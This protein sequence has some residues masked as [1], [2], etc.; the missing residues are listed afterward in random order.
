[1]RSWLWGWFLGTGIL[2]VACGGKVIVDGLPED[3]T[4]G[5]GGGGAT[6]TGSTTS[7]TSTTGTASTGGA[8]MACV[9]KVCNTLCTVCNN[10]ECIQGKCDSFGICV[11]NQPKCP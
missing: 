2:L 3:G 9:G 8:L 10:T 4:G 1:M 7:G 5:A 11:P 6:T